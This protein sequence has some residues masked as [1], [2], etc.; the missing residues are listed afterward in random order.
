MLT[1]STLIVACHAQQ[2][3]CVWG[4]CPCVCLPARKC[5]GTRARPETLAARDRAGGATVTAPG[6]GWA[7]LE[8][9]R[10]YGTM[11][12]HVKEFLLTSHFPDTD[13]LLYKRPLVALA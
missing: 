12:L 9:L 4:V 7:H 2:L 10:L 3:P 6:E 8:I 5:G 1:P 11:G 13:R